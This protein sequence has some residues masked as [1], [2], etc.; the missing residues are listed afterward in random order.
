VVVISQDLDCKKCVICAEIQPL[1]NYYSKGRYLESHCKVC[2]SKTKRKRYLLKKKVKI[3][4]Y[5]NIITK[6]YTS[7]IATEMTDF[8][9]ELESFLLEEFKGEQKVCG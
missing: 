5:K 8:M 3:D 9:L 7:T 6:P 1:S 4:R 2:V